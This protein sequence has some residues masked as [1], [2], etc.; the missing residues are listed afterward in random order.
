MEHLIH[1]D[2]GGRPYSSR[3]WEVALSRLAWYETAENK[4]MEKLGCTMEGLLEK[5]ERGYLLVRGVNVAELVDCPR[6]SRG[7]ERT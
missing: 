1:Y 4:V 2:E 7:E 3:G 5:L 6:T